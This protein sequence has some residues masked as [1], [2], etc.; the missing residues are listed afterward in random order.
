MSTLL[1]CTALSFVLFSEV[2]KNPSR[3]DRNFFNPAAMSRQR[4]K[5]G[6]RAVEC[7]GT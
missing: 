2:D 6:G 1:C 4:R 5:L 7:G 3:R